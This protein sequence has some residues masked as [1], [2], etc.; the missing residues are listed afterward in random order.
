VELVTLVAGLVALAAGVALVI[1]GR[2]AHADGER[3][4]RIA[5]AELQRL[6]AEHAASAAEH[7][8][9]RL[10]LDSMQ[11]GILLFSPTGSLRF[12]N[13][14]ADM[15]LSTVPQSRAA[16]LPLGLREAA[17]RAS[18]GEPTS[19]EVQVG[20]PTT[21]IRGT[22]LPVEPDGSVLLVLADV[23]ETKR[24]DAVRRDFV[25]NAS[26]E[27]KTPAAAIQ[28]MAE[29]IAG[30]AVEDPGVVP[31]FAEQLEREASRLSRI[32][33]DLLDLSRLESGSE[34]RELVRLDAI[35]RDE[36]ERAE[37]A[38]ER[39]GVAL[40]FDV[41]PMV[42][43]VLGSGRDLSLLVRNLL[44]NAVRYTRPG[45]SVDIRVAANG[46]NVVLVVAD[47]GVGIPSRDV[48]RIFERF[49]RVDRARSRET[50]GTGLGLSIVRHVTE[51]HHGSIDVRSELG[52]GS[53]FEVRLPTAP[54]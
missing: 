14:A 44:D 38:A 2:R 3:R 4:E 53:T 9:T 34:L 6:R 36:R 35:V 32:V 5:V 23:T 49:Y 54:A 47:T 26:H 1:L 45:G 30:A 24:I 42:P 12:A 33:A 13:A 37:S 50:G 22:A 11:E 28:A 17:E 20:A 21:W 46:S 25:A 16:L 48:D 8:E 15:H 18:A 52:R 29:T 43:T 7:A 51:N 39:G 40:T 19:A 10:V 41:P 27:L 31:R